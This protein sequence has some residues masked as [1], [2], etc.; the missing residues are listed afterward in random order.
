[1]QTPTLPPYRSLLAYNVHSIPKRSELVREAAKALNTTELKEKVQERQGFLWTTDPVSNSPLRAPVVSDCL[2][3]LYNKETILYYITKAPGYEKQ[4]EQ[5]EEILDGYVKKFKDLVEV[6]FEDDP[7]VGRNG[8]LKANDGANGNANGKRVTKW[9]C[10]VS[11]KPLGPGSK[12]VY[13]VPC[14]HAFASVALKE[15]KSEEC[16][17][18]GQAYQANDI[19]R[20]VPATEEE[21]EDLERRITTYKAHGLSHSSAARKLEKKEKKRDKDENGKKRKRD[22]NADPADAVENGMEKKD[23]KDEKGKKRKKDPKVDL[24][25]ALG[26]RKE[27]KKKHV[28][29]NGAQA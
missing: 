11:G 16:L 2:G 22:A 23:D 27:N 18:C 17:Q 9:I 3:R 24:E 6:H 15:V 29:A 12:A 20:I 28:D 26:I 13:L 14:G 7:D 4:N 1:V 21:L 25:D 10:P 19:I 8:K 5:A